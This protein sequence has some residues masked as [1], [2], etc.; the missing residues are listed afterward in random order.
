[1]TTIS[2]LGNAVLARVGLRLERVRAP[3]PED[4]RGHDDFYRPAPTCQIPELAT[5]YRLFLG[6]RND[7]LFVEVGAYD[8]ISFSNSSC[9]ADAGW[10]GILIEPIP[11]FAQACRDRYH[12]NARIQVVDAAVGDTAA[13][14]EFTIAGPF[15]STNDDVIRGYER[16]DWAKEAVKNSTRLTV[17]QRILDEI[18]AASGAEGKAIDVLIVDVEGAEASVFAGFSLEKWM[19]TMIIVELSHT[20]PDLHDISA[21]D[22]AVQRSI[23]NAGYA[24]VYKDRINTVFVAD[25]PSLK[26]RP[27]P[28][29]DLRRIAEV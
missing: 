9:L 16:L 2:R 12:G 14:V 10:N 23:A 5:L 28:G 21:G 19:P 1:M 20:H 29:A 8:G 24:V 15:T 11:R 7:G 3:D 6:E 18:L 26:K 25:E 17:R 27:A 4:L 22:A 13:D